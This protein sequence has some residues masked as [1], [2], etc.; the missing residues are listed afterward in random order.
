MVILGNATIQTNI[1][2]VET[3]NDYRGSE[4]KEKAEKSKSDCHIEEARM[5]DTTFFCQ[6]RFR[7]E[8]IEKELR[9]V[10]RDSSSKA[11]ACRRMAEMETLGYI[12]FASCTNEKKAE[13]VNQYQSR[14]HFTKDDFRKV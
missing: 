13:L 4:G 6:D 3:Y 2:H 11:D 7:A 1:E 9:K 8:I 12:S 14:F 5:V 10:F